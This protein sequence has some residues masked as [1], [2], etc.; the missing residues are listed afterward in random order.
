[1]NT[2]SNLSLR[3]IL[4]TDALTCLACGALMA[5]GASSLAAW[6][7]IPES[8]L[9]YAGLSLFPISALMAF[10]ALKA[11]GSLPL[12]WLVI[13]GNS[14]WAAA[15][16]WLSASGVIAPNTL[17]TTFILFQAVVVGVLTALEIRGVS[18]KQSLPA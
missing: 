7:Q 3:S 14:L 6:L 5:I 17:G 12:V 15:S 13:A 18:T 10:V 1:M 16:V 2:R 11:L 4:L 9:R 8:L